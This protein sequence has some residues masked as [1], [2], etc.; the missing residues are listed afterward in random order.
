MRLTTKAQPSSETFKS[1]RAAHLAML[2]QVRQAAELA[3]R[4][5]AHVGEI[6]RVEVG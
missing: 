4:L 5:H 1:N 2:D 6:L 3:A